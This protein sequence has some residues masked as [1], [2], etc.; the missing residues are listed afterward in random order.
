MRRLVLALFLYAAV[1]AAG[2]AW[3]VP[4]ALA[5]PLPDGPD[6]FNSA[7]FTVRHSWVKFAA[8]L[9]RPLAGSP[10]RAE[11]DRLVARFFA[12]N[13]DI[14]AQERI[15][16][17]PNS[18]PQQ[19]ADAAAAADAMRAERH[20]MQDRVERILEGRLTH[21]AKEAGLTRH[22][23]S[24]IIWPPPNIH[25]QEPPAV[26]VTSPR[27]EIR[28]E[29]QRLLR[30]ELPIDRI[31]QLERAAEADG[32]TSALVVQIGGIA[33]YPAIIPPDDDYA[34]VLEDIAHEW[35]HQYLY[36]APLG[37]NYFT[38]DKLTTLNE[39]V[40]DIV[41]REL[42]QMLLA[43]YPLDAP[44]AYVAAAPVAP[45]G[46]G[47]SAQR[48]RIDFVAEMRGLRREVETLLAQGQIEQAEARM[49]QER[50]F[51]AANGFYIR[52]LNQAYFAFHGSYA[53]SAGSIDPIGP[54]LDALRA[55]RSTLAAFV[56]TV[57]QF[58]SEADLDRALAGG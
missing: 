53:D 28:K 46:R 27:S 11:E 29:G 38:S 34:F 55:Q 44:P 42:G 35:M 54:K 41:G 15:A 36:F 31:Q 13:R 22:L 18:P 14:A 5:L 6:D 12:L 1:C 57:Q 2:L 40:A 21:V 19:A 3:S 37:R 17:D 25:F 10:S 30:G 33:M 23:G 24:D 49:E 8:V 39:T 16:G 7:G 26:L 45:A 20:A 58:R 47:E 50:E 52:R 48:Q 4:V 51:L 9:G 32:Q 56:H 43:E